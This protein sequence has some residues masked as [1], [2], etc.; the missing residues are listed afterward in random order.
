MGRIKIQFKTEGAVTLP[1][2][3]QKLVNSY[4]HRCIGPNEFHDAQSKYNYSALKGGTPL[5]GKQELFPKGAY[6]LVSF[7]EKSPEGRAFFERLMSGL[8]TTE[9]GH[10]FNYAG[11]SVTDAKFYDGY[12]M[13]VSVDPVL[14][15]NSENRH[16]TVEESGAEEY[17]KLL[18]EHT[19][20]KLNKI[21]PKLD[22]SGFNIEVREG[23][24]TIYKEVGNQ[25]N[26]GSK[27]IAK[28]DC[29]RTVAKTIYDYGL[30]QSTGSG[31]GLIYDMENRDFH[32]Q[33]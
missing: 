3:S 9:F 11:M 28:I 24:K 22:L 29:N 6:I 7:D 19:I 5:N 21:N 17:S 33:Y 26:F 13:F 1:L 30:G 32:V 31:F 2:H 25:F 10:G 27:I 8:F 16:M 15:K 4:I 14:L 12:N 20:R 23:A 18:T